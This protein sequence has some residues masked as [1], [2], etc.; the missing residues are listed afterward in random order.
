MKALVKTV[1]GPANLELKEIP[2][3]AIGDDDLLIRVDFCAV[4]G[5]DLHIESGNHPCEPPV[6]LGH[7]FSGTV[8][9]TGANVADFEVGDAVAYRQG[10]HPFPGVKGDGGFAEYMRVPATSMWKTPDNISQE[11]ATQFEMAICPLTV[12]RDLVKLQ[13]GETVVVTGPG[14]FGLLAANLAK[15]EGAARVIVLGASADAG[16]RLPKALEVGADEASVCSEE[17]LARIRRESPPTCWLETSG[18]PAAVKAAVDTVARRGRISLTGLSE[19]LSTLNM[20]RVAWD[21]LRI[22]GLWGSNNAYIPDVAE[23]IGSGQLNVKAIISNI[24]PLTEWQAAFSM[25]RH[26]DGIKILLDPS[27]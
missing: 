4:C 23:M 11:E 22:C 3:P 21:S 13:P 12:I 15:I 8:A 17:V 26:M 14:P 10:W 18:A 16:Q 25:L 20:S 2:I 5:S 27:R 7:E 6:V 9:E 1:S 24:M 19:E